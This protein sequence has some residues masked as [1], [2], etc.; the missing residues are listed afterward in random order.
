MSVTVP[1]VVVGHF[2][3]PTSMTFLSNQIM[4][5]HSSFYI[6]QHP[7]RVRAGNGATH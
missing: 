4:V 6:T 5:K 7:N 3:T 1:V 2:S